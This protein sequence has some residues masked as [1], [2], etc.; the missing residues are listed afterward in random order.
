MR[1][2]LGSHLV[3]RV[4]KMVC[5]IQHHQQTILSNVRLALSRSFA[6][7]RIALFLIGFEAACSNFFSMS[8]SNHVGWCG[9]R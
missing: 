9:N 7:F 4:A 2:Y 8:R 6:A 5:D 1:S 3:F